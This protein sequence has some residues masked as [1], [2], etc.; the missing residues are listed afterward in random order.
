[1]A[2]F[3]RPDPGLLLNNG[4]IFTFNLFFSGNLDKAVVI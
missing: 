1:M 4:G 3:T 2:A